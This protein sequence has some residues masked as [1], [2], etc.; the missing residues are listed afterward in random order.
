MQWYSSHLIS[1]LSTIPKTACTLPLSYV[2]LL[3]FEAQDSHMRR[4]RAT[5][6]RFLSSTAVRLHHTCAVGGITDKLW[7][8]AVGNFLC[9]TARWGHV[10]T[11]LLGLPAAQVK[12]HY[13]LC[14][15]WAASFS[16][17]HTSCV[18]RFERNKETK[19]NRRDNIGRWIS[20]TRIVK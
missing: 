10:S 14:R 5:R 19:Q 17:G 1:I 3:I 15:S 2:L 7:E 18:K 9:P 11:L 16:K 6:C 20:S 12:P 4:Y 8:I 13:T